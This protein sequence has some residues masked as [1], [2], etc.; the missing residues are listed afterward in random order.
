MYFGDKFPRGADFTGAQQIKEGNQIRKS[1]VLVITCAHSRMIHLELTSNMTAEEFIQALRRS[2]N[3]RGWC[4]SIESD[5]QPTLKRTK[6]LFNIAFSK[7][8]GKHLKKQNLTSFLLTTA[9]NG[10]L[11][12]KEVHSAALIG[13]E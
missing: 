6:K 2:F 13:N 9:L 3:R 8:D 7:K 10:G 12:L 5:S 1:Y 11:S 4:R